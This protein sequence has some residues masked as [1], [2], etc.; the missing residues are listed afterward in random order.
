MAASRPN[1]RIP[2]DDGAEL[3]LA[4]TIAL[5][6]E[7]PV[8]RVT[9]RDIATRAGL[10]TMHVKRYFGSRNELLVAVSNR[11]MTRIV[12]ALADKPL[13]KIFPFLQQNNDVTLRLRIISHLIDEGMPADSFADDRAVYTRIAERIA[14]VNNVGKR[15]ARTYSHIIQLVLQGNRLMGDVNGLTPRQ[16]RDIFELLA[17]LNSGLAP[18]EKSLGW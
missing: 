8:S 1:A 16:R 18:A 11:L 7:G 13:E 17:V 14:A 15:T 2:R 9:V 5:A 4:A 10:Q 3:L 12:D 6:G